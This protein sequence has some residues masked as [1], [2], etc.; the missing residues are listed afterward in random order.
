MRKPYDD[1]ELIVGGR[2]GPRPSTPSSPIQA[3]NW[4]LDNYN[5]MDGVNSSFIHI[6]RPNSH[7]SPLDLESKL[8]KYIFVLV[9]DRHYEILPIQM[10]LT[11]Y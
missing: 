3:G 4:V 10:T 1:M 7:L 8:E 11:S 6:Q 2:Y 9:I 5:G